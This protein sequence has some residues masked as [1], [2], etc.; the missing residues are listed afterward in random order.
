MLAILNCFNIFIYNIQ[1][2]ALSPDLRSM[3][4]ATLWCSSTREAKE[5][6]DSE[7]DDPT[8]LKV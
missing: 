3:S 7:V 8:K 1:I 5:S 2:T 6:K 4:I